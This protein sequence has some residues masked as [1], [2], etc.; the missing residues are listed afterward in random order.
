MS[1]MP[2]EATLWIKDVEGEVVPQPVG[3]YE[4]AVEHEK[5]VII[6]HVQTGE[7]TI[8]IVFRRGEFSHLVA[9]PN[10]PE[11]AKEVAVNIEM[12]EQDDG[13]EDDG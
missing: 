2:G 9:N 8:N 12:E 5:Q 6:L 10:D 1:S 4:S 11:A 3:V 13:P 7:A